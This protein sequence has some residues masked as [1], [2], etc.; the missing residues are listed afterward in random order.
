[1]EDVK[2]TKKKGNE[3]NQEENA[4]I[5]KYVRGIRPRC[6]DAGFSIVTQSESSTSEII[7]TV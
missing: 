2:R 1:M 7:F 4:S 6:F 5:C 3:Y